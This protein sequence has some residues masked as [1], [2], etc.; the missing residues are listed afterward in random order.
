MNI[1]QPLFERPLEILSDCG[2]CIW[3]SSLEK[4]CAQKHAARLIEVHNLIPFVRWTEEDLVTDQSGARIFHLKWQLSVLLTDAVGA[5]IGFLV[6]Y[7]RP[8]DN[9]FNYTSVY[10]H[11]MAIVKTLQRRGIGH[12]VISVYLNEVFAKLDVDYVTLQANDNPQNTRIIE[13][14]E[15]LGFKKVKHV[16]YADKTDWLMV[17]TRPVGATY[18]ERRAK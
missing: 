17:C 14:Y 3:I 13:L 5:P 4:A 9:N 10:M 11:R 8:S 6:S 18:S 1:T 12:R 7:L 2:D 16:F 15:S